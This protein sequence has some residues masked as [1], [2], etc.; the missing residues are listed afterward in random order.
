MSGDEVCWR[1]GKRFDQ[2]TRDDLAACTALAGAP[3][4]PGPL[5]YTDAEVAEGWAGP[6]R[7]LPWLH[8]RT[9]GAIESERTP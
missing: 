6:G 5:H 8:H 1:C 3:G 7:A 2:T 4:D 9:A